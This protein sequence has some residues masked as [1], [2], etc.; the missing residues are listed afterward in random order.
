MAIKLIQRFSPHKNIDNRNTTTKITPYY[1]HSTH[2]NIIEEEPYDHPRQH[3]LWPTTPPIIAA[4]KTSV[5]QYKTTA[6]QEPT[7]KNENRII[8]QSS[9]TYREF[10]T[11]GLIIEHPSSY[12]LDTDKY[13]PDDP[14]WR[15]A[16]KNI[17]YHHTK[18][19]ASSWFCFKFPQQIKALM[20]PLTT[21]RQHG[22]LQRKVIRELTRKSRTSTITWHRAW[23]TSR[24]Q[25][26]TERRAQCQAQDASNNKQDEIRE[27]F[28]KQAEA[29]I[30]AAYTTSDMSPTN[31]A[32]HLEK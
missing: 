25:R 13:S 28:R 10:W 31:K 4:K 26:D 6:T 17:L 8:G 9:Y 21:P 24:R 2:V 20:Q 7:T 14:E 18:A 12:S 32:I 30:A 23:L 16:W 29:E 11:H 3:V 19:F 22:K 15:T 5:T 1:T 27:R